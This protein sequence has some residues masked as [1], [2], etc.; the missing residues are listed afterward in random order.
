MTQPPPSRISARIWGLIGIAALAVV[1]GFFAEIALFFQSF[2]FA[3]DACI[4]AQGSTSATRTV[5]FKVFPLVL[6]AGSIVGY[7]GALRHVKRGGG[8]WPAWATFG[9]S[10]VVLVAQSV[11]VDTTGA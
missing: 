1:I 8:L 3:A 9:A 11:Y 4:A 6:L 10:M 5:A 2:C 7:A